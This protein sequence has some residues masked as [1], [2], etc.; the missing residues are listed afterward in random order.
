MSKTKAT[1][2]MK[3]LNTPRLFLWIKGFLH[4][5]IIHTGGIDPE[6]GTIASG[7]ITGQIKLFHSACTIRSGQA[8]TKLK[9][10]WDEA[11]NLLI[12]YACVCSELK[13]SS[14]HQESVGESNAQARAREMADKARANHEAERQDIL[15]KLAGLSNEVRD[16]EALARSQM[17]ATRDL[18]HSTFASYG[19]GLLM[20]PVFSHN[21][22]VVT[23]DDCADQILK[24]HEG[25][26]NSVVSI[27]KEVTK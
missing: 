14:T 2:P 17:E 20:K 5:K 3:G 25:T 15:E 18:L 8:S 1:L 12:Q 11:D 21:I 10:T 4:G 16:E 9:K 13:E 24:S 26:W 27:L 7:Y 22:P 23:C 19:H 6:T